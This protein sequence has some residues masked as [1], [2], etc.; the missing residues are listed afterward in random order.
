MASPHAVSKV[1]FLI[2]GLVPPALAGLSVDPARNLVWLIPGTI[3]YW[4]V[5]GVFKPLFDKYVTER[6]QQWLGHHFEALFGGYRR[7]YVDGLRR[8]LNWPDVEA[9]DEVPLF[10][11]P[12]DDVYVDLRV[13]HPPVGDDES[14]GPTDSEREEIAHFIPPGNAGLY[15]ITGNAG[16]GKTSLLKSTGLRIL[17]RSRWFGRLP[18]FIELRNHVEEILAEEPASIPSIVGRQPWRGEKDLTG[19]VRSKFGRSCWLV[20]L[21]GLDEI[22]DE[23]RRRRLLAWVKTQRV[24][25]PRHMY[26]LTSR[27]DAKS[28]ARVLDVEELVIQAFTREQ[29]TTFVC[30]WYQEVRLWQLRVGATTLVRDPAGQANRLINLIFGRKSLELYKLAANPLLLTMIVNIHLHLG[31]L[32]ESRFKLYDAITDMLLHKRQ[33]GKQIS[34]ADGLAHEQR[35]PV[36]RALAVH[37]AKKGQQDFTVREVRGLITGLLGQYEGATVEAFLKHGKHCDFLVK[38]DDREYHFFHRSHQEFLTA[39]AVLEGE[40]ELSLLTANVG[41]LTWRETILLWAANSDVTPVVEACLAN[42]GIRALRLALTCQAEGRTISPDTDK[43]LDEQLTLTAGMDRAGLRSLAA[44]LLHGELREV[45]WIGGDAMLSGQPV[46]NKLYSLY[47]IDRELQ[48]RTPAAA[49]AIESPNAAAAGMWEDD[50]AGFL[51]WVN[52]LPE[53]EFD[54]RLPTRNEL[55][56]RV[57]EIEGFIGRQGWSREEMGAQV[58]RADLGSVPHEAD[59]DGA[60]RSMEAY[61]QPYAPRLAPFLRSVRMVFLSQ[62]IKNIITDLTTLH[63]SLTEADFDSG[64]PRFDRVIPGMKRDKKYLPRFM[65]PALRM[66]LDAETNL[67]AARK[68][69][70]REQKRTPQ[71]STT[72]RNLE[73]KIAAATDEDHEAELRTELEMEQAELVSRQREKQRKAEQRYRKV[74]SDTRMNVVTLISDLRGADHTA[75]SALAE[76]A[77]VESLP[78]LRDPDTDIDKAIDQTLAAAFAQAAPTDQGRDQLIMALL[79]KSWSRNERRNDQLGPK[80][81]D[82]NYFLTQVAREH[83]T[84]IGQAHLSGAAPGINTVVT[85]LQNLRTGKKA[86]EG[87][88]ALAEY[89]RTLVMPTLMAWTVLDLAA[90]WTARVAFVAIWAGAEPWWDKGSLRKI[91]TALAAAELRGNGSIPAD[92]LLILALAER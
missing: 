33:E 87:V 75:R 71:R 78:V 54:F 50:A 59:D 21:D 2:A 91:N 6:L 52:A 80:R 55:N 13:R 85:T 31:D 56:D 22:T 77:D 60:V 5:L 90:L 61:L 16:A 12:L 41:E 35:L 39:C 37:L 65:E 84:S 3:G 40:E 38:S 32:P 62:M 24:H 42:G 73:A 49:A 45:L 51:D 64:H 63:E 53:R 47:L 76:L 83:T 27:P 74:L 20:M 82:V 92:E 46:S 29:I 15:V 11:M 44:V 9:P 70:E 25:Y 88:I 10:R 43:R 36:F 8:R 17:K 81:F 14:I 86:P 67:G 19:W 79:A 34:A 30:G 28:F 57:E 89:A 1:G 68:A 26:L 72:V 69:M 18:V 58:V 23:A 4:V 7:V 48:S 66:L